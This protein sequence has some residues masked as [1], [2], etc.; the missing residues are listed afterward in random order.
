MKTK[1]KKEIK[2]KKKKN[3]KLI[4]FKKKVYFQFS[5]LFFIHS[6]DSLFE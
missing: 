5:L 6:Y 4:K 2:V 1:K 3:K